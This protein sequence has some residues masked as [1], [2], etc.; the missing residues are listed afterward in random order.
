MF[1]QPTHASYKT[2]QLQNFARYSNIGQSDQHVPQVLCILKVSAKV[3]E[4]EGKKAKYNAE[5]P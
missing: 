1:S 5:E 2:R 4:I 3:R